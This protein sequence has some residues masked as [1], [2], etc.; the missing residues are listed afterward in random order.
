MTVRGRPT[1]LLPYLLAFVLGAGAAALTACGSSNPAMIPLQ[2]AN[3]LKSDLDAVKSAVDAKDCENTDKTLAQLSAD[4]ASLPAKVATRIKNRLREGYSA[5]DRQARRE[6]EK[7]ATTQTQ[8]TET[9]Q[10]QTTPTETTQTQTIPTTTTE[11]TPTQTTPT[12][13]DSIPT[14][15]DSIPTTT[16]D[17]GGTTTP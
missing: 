10:T 8:T 15:T 2:N 14:T 13:T 12:T 6:C 17:T 16:N 3:H 9:T 11:T 5:L 7:T 1:R 4:I